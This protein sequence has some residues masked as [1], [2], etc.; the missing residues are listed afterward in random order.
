MLF[1]VVRSFSLT[2]LLAVGGFLSPPGGK[3]K[4]V[5]TPWLPRFPIQIRSDQIRSDAQSCPTLCDPMNRS[6]PGLPIQLC[7]NSH[8]AHSIPSSPYSEVL[9]PSARV[10]DQGGRGWGLRLPES[11]PQPQ[12]RD[13]ESLALTPWMVLQKPLLSWLL[14]DGKNGAECQFYARGLIGIISFDLHIKKRDLEPFPQTRKLRLREGK[15]LAQN[16]T[17][18]RQWSRISSPGGYFK[19]DFIFFF[20]KGRLQS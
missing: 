2:V 11:I 8:P 16:H 1:P 20:Q 13:G 9:G 6:T 19:K 18:W 14:L 15:W 3:T 4:S 12:P 5:H 7:P 17:A 10:E